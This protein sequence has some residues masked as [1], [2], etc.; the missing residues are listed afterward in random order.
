M[1]QNKRAE[2]RST[3]GAVLMR[4]IQGT[5][6][7]KLAMFQEICAAG[8]F[9][10][11][12]PADLREAEMALRK[13]AIAERRR[14]LRRHPRSRNWSPI[15]VLHNSFARPR[16]TSPTRTKPTPSRFACTFPNL[17]R[18]RRFLWL[19]PQNRTSP[20]CLGA[21]RW[22]VWIPASTMV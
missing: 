5:A 18:R 14:L 17:R 11:E 3:V 9:A 16:D 7:A 2:Q 13:L 15:L 10:D 21:S 12:D 8:G 19:V 4:D 22:L 6:V 1:S 20:R